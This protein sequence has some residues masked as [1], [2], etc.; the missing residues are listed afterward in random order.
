[1]NVTNVPIKEQMK[2][3]QQDTCLAQDTSIPIKEQKKYYQQRCLH[4]S[5]NGSYTI[6]T[7]RTQIKFNN[8]TIA[9]TYEEANPLIKLVQIS[10]I[11]QRQNRHGLTILSMQTTREPWKLDIAN[12]LRWQT[13]RQLCSQL[14]FG[15]QIKILFEHM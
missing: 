7:Y 5:P 12:I 13:A 1:M 11:I 4:S 3:H 9:N 15:S 6:C 2:L 14:H 8:R 10:N